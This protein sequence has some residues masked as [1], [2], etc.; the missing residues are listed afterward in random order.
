M[1]TQSRTE[2]IRRFDA[3]G[4]RLDA[5]GP[6]RTQPPA[7]TSEALDRAELPLGVWRRRARAQSNV[8]TLRIPSWASS[9]SKP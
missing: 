1:S 8:I 4:V 7:R 2:D 3:R 9:S 5:G 6:A